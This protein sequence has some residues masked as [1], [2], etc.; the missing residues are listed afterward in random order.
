MALSRYTRCSINI[1]NALL[2]I[3]NYGLDSIV[4]GISGLIPVGVEH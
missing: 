1:I 2:S 3:N 4:G